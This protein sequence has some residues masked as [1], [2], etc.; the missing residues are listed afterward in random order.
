MK[1]VISV[2][3]LTMMSLVAV[4]PTIAFHYCGNRLQSIE[5]SS[6]EKPSCCGKKNCCSDR[7]V[8][9]T[10]GHF[11][12]PQQ[13]WSVDLFSFLLKPVL[14]VFFDDLFEKKDTTVSVLLQTVFPPGGLINRHVN[15][16][17]FLCIFR[18]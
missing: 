14:F 16:H 1:Q 15:L 10:T 3:L 8:Q 4:Q 7:I 17:I 13:A 5:I 9:I 18:N 2:F 6:L 11:Q 12:A